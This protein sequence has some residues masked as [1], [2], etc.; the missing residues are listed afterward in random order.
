[1]ATSALGMGFDKP[2]LG[3]VVHVG[4]TPSPVAYYQ[5]IG[6]AGRG[7]DHALVVLLPSP[8]DEPVWEYFATATIPVA[9]DVHT[10]LAAMREAQEPM[11]VPALESTTGL[12]RSGVEL[13]LKQLAVDGAVDRTAEGWLA[14]GREWTSIRSTTTECWPAGVA[15]RPSC[16]TTS[17]VRPV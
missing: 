13:M 12:R 1:M 9:A 7:L 14:T 17:A 10:L 3:F 6:R 15:R 11:T 2:D 5:Q 8:A 4:A 16:A